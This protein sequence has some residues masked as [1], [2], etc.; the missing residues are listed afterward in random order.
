MARSAAEGD[1]VNHGE[2]GPFEVNGN[3][4]VDQWGNE[5]LTYKQARTYIDCSDLTR[6]QAK[7][8]IARLYLITGGNKWL[9]PARIRRIIEAI[10]NERI[11]Q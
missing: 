4:R 2:S 11:T 9:S 1:Q 7:L 6:T 5:R 8:A 10:S 3:V